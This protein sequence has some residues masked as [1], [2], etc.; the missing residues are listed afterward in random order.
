MSTLWPETFSFLIPRNYSVAY[1][2]STIGERKIIRQERDGTD[3]V[4]I[5]P[6][7]TRVGIVFQYSDMRIELLL[8]R[9]QS[10]ALLDSIGGALKKLQVVEK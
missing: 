3:K 2:I 1:N 6:P 5:L 4:I 10:E 9:D 8:T 7:E